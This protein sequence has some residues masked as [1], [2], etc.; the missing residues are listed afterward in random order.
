MVPRKAI[1]DFFFK[2]RFFIREGSRCCPSH[3]DEQEYF[4]PEAISKIQPLRS[5]AR[6]DSKVVESFIDELMI[7]IAKNESLFSEFKDLNIVDFERVKNLTGLSKEEFL[8]VSTHLNSMRDSHYR[9][10]SQAL[11]VYYF[12]FVHL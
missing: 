3:F 12:G 5:G 1:V 10:R 7:K 4:N 6:V 8:F 2:T 9:D 11:F